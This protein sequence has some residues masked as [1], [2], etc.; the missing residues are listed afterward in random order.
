ML[1]L[2]VGNC[3]KRLISRIIQKRYIFEAYSFTFISIN[4]RFSWGKILRKPQ[5]KET[6]TLKA[7]NL[8]ETLGTT[9][10][11]QRESYV[12]R[13]RDGGGGG[14]RCGC[15]SAYTCGA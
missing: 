11:Q 15:A 14:A 1:F 6:L 9:V 13:D 12:H 10:L 8:S 4:R 3:K 2:K 5:T 7:S